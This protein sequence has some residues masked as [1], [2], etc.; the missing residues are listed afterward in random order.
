L[1]RTAQRLYAK[2]PLGVELSE[3]V[4]ALDSIIDLCMSLFPWAP[5]RQAKAAVKLHCKT[6]TWVVL[7]GQVWPPCARR[8]HAGARESPAN[9]ESRPLPPRNIPSTR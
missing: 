6:V 1:I 3:T 4:Y 7:V 2:E 5:F 9:G 8:G